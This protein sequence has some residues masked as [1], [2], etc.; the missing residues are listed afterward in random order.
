MNVY[1]YPASLVNERLLVKL[2]MYELRDPWLATFASG[3][4]AMPLQ[5]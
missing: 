4:L 3:S 1:L 2:K 5:Y